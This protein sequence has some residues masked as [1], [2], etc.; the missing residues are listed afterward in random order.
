MQVSYHNR[1]AEIVRKAWSLYTNLLFSFSKFYSVFMTSHPGGVTLSTVHGGPAIVFHVDSVG[2]GYTTS[3]E[4]VS[5]TRSPSAEHGSMSKTSWIAHALESTTRHELVPSRDAL[6]RPCRTWG[7]READA[8][9][10]R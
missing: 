8:A 9:N 4:L 3:C 2:E 1:H 6:T 5:T 7:T 10:E